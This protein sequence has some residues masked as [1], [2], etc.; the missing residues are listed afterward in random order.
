LYWFDLIQLDKHTLWLHLQDHHK[1]LEKT[2]MAILDLQ[3]CKL[4]SMIQDNPDMAIGYAEAM[5]QQ[6]MQLADMI[7]D[8]T[9]F[10]LPLG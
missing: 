10:H 6:V 5:T 2:T 4:L 9:F 8:M 1:V 7:A 3:H